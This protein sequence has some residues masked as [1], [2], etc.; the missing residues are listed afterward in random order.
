MKSSKKRYNRRK[1]RQYKAGPGAKPIHK[2]QSGRTGHVR[3]KRIKSTQ[4]Q[5]IRKNPAVVIVSSIAIVPKFPK[6]GILL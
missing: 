5:S 4:R 1:R 2:L 6:I 3:T